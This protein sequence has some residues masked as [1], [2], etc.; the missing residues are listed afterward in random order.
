LEVKA[1]GEKISGAILAISGQVEVYLLGAIDKDKENARL[2]KEKANLEKL[3]E[4]QIKKLANE[5]F[6]SRAPEKI[7]ALE[8]EKIITYQQDL[9]KVTRALTQL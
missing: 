6:V 5:E 8:K 4:L 3:L 7:V 1:A 2:L 9:E